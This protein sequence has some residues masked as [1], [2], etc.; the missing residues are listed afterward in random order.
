MK[1]WSNVYDASTPRGLSRMIHE[2]M[3]QPDSPFQYRKPTTCVVS[4]IG[5]HSTLLEALKVITDEYD[6]EVGRISLE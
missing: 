1:Y 6:H 5:E 2:E 3:N 4:F